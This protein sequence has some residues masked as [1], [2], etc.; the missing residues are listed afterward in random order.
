MDITFLGPLA[1]WLGLIVCAISALGLLVWGRGALSV[2]RIFTAAGFTSILA[3]AT[4]VFAAMA[5]V[6]G[7]IQRLYNR[8][9][10]LD[11]ALYLN[12]PESSAK[13]SARVILG[14]INAGFV[15]AENISG[16]ARLNLAIEFLANMTLVLAIS[17]VVFRIAWS[18]VREQGFLSQMPTD[19]RVLAVVTLLTQTVSQ[20]SGSVAKEQISHELFGANIGSLQPQATGGMNLPLWQIFVAIAIW[21][22]ARLIHRGV[23]LQR[24]NAGLV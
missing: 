13:N 3:M 14:A 4:A 5:T 6:G 19:L 21:V 12:L 24:D 17:I 16:E 10:N 9:L 7:T 2:R 11:T 8:V 20:W 22:L 15:R 23:Q 1:P 18:V